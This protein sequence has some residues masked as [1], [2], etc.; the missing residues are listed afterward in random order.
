MEPAVHKTLLSA[1][2]GVI[3]DSRDKISECLRCSERTE[4]TLIRL[5]ACSNA[6][7]AMPRAPSQR[8]ERA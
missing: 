8:V 4:P 1:Q 7:A 3:R 5:G 2:T 6:L